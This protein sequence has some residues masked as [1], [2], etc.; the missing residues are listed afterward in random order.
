ML[1]RWCS[2]KEST[3]NARDTGSVTDSGR[4]LGEG[5]SNPLQH[6]CLGNPMDK[7]AWRATV[8]VVTKNQT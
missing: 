2:G 6:S 5:D 8:H 4:S 3:A 1:L 7:E